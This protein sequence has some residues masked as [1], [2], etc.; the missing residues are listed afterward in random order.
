MRMANDL[1]IMIYDITIYDYDDDKWIVKSLKD[2]PY[3]VSVA[4][5]Y[6][7]CTFK[8]PNNTYLYLI[9]LLY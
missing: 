9:S 1:Y 2:K 8:Y 7:L 3:L 4:D 5:N 6:I